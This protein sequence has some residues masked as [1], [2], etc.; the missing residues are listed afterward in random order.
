MVSLVVASPYPK[1]IEPLRALSPH[2]PGLCFPTEDKKGSREGGSQAGLSGQWR[3][4]L[5]A[6]KTRSLLVDLSIAMICSA[7]P[8][9]SAPPNAVIFPPSFI[10]CS[11]DPGRARER[12]R[13]RASGR[14]TTSARPVTSIASSHSSCRVRF[15]GRGAAG[16]V[17]GRHEK[18][19]IAVFSGNDNEAHHP[20][21]FP[22]VETFCWCSIE[23]YRNRFIQ[24]FIPVSANFCSSST[25]E[26]PVKRLSLGR[27]E[28]VLR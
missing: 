1:I 17:D 18:H 5:P 28:L 27:M 14:R 20:S 25:N 7:A 9:A 22:N 10:M 13:E 12:G 23:L 11:H 3:Y 19:A 15:D 24:G 6:A 26:H 8:P 2:L 16:D 21:L 4:F